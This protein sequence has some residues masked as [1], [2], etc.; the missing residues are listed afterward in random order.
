MLRLDSRH[1]SEARVPPS[2][3]QHDLSPF[4]DTNLLLSED[5]MMENILAPFQDN[6]KDQTVFQMF[7]EPEANPER[8]TDLN[9]SVQETL[10]PGPEDDRNLKNE[11]LYVDELDFATQSNRFSLQNYKSHHA[12]F[13]HD[14]EPLETLVDGEE[15]TVVGPE[16]EKYMNARSAK[17]NNKMDLDIPDDSQRTRSDC[18]KQTNLKES[19]KIDQI[20]ENNVNENKKRHRRRKIALPVMRTSSILDDKDERRL[21]TAKYQPG[22]TQRK[23]ANATKHE[24]REQETDLIKINVKRVELQNITSAMEARR[25]SLRQQIR[26]TR[27]ER[28][29]DEFESRQKRLKTV[30]RV[31]KQRT[32]KTERDGAKTYRC[33]E[34][35]RPK[36]TG[37]SSV[38]EDRGDFRR[39]T[40][41]R[42]R[43]RRETRP[44][45]NV[46]VTNVS[47]KMHEMST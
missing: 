18:N 29:D 45:L 25:A 16:T 19:P 28:L 3:V 41:A 15:N 32:T 34:G 38:E 5:P 26:K 43:L 8:Q 20:E 10:H 7:T 17:G 9:A 40:E 27:G 36:K 23:S 24:A 21:K 12:S 33:S 35:G 37:N 6:V 13:P 22:K 4:N 11:T 30:R 44:K 31:G 42:Q 2:A 47:E 1:G 14:P 39:K 46:K